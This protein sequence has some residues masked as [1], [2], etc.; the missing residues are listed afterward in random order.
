MRHSDSLIGYIW[1]QF[2][3]HEYATLAFTPLNK[4]TD[5]RSD[6]RCALPLYAQHIVH[7]KKFNR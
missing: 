2:Q 7:R 5:A 6:A 3:L 4:K 1:I